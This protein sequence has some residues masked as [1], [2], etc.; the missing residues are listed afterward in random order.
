[1][2]TPLT[3]TEEDGLLRR[4]AGDR[5]L[6]SYIGSLIDSVL[7]TKGV[8]QSEAREL[9]CTLFI[10]LPVAMETF[11]AADRSYKFSTYFS[12]RIRQRISERMRAR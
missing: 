10:D 6:R 12:W 1:M 5:V 11:R 3:K 9:K 8:R 4:G 7:L 2:F